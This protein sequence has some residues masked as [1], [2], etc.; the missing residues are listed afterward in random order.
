MGNVKNLIFLNKEAKVKAIAKAKGI[1][2]AKEHIKSPHLISF[3]INDSN[4]WNNGKYKGNICVV[5]DI[6]FFDLESDKEGFPSK[7]KVTHNLSWDI[8]GSSTFE[9]EINKFIQQRFTKKMRC[10][11]SE[12]GMQENKLAD[13]DIEYSKTKFVK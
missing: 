8:Y 10:T 12:Q 13:M 7:L 3:V 4:D 6:Q 1:F 2:K 11:F 9:K 5:L